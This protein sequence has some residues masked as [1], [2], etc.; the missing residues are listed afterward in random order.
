MF[1]T[2]YKR[3][4]LFV[5]T[6]SCTLSLLDSGL[7]GLLLQPIKEDLHL[8]DTQLGLLTGIVFGLFYAVLG[9]P[10]ARWADRG[11]RTTITGV[12][13]ALWGLAVMTSLFV[14]N[15]MQLLLM[16]IGA[17]VG[18][19]G[20]RPP[21]YSL[22]GDYF[23]EAAERTRAMALYWTSGPLAALL[24]FV[25]GGWLN[26]QY[27]WRV[28][29]FLVGIPG[30]LAAL[31]V[32]LSISEPRLRVPRVVTTEQPSPRMLEVLAT[33]WRRHATRHI[34]IALILVQTMAVGLNPWIAAFMIRSHGM[35]TTEVGLWLGS[36]LG[37]G[38]FAGALLGGYVSA[39]WFG[40]DER[41]QMRMSAL[42]ISAL[43]PC[44]AA[45]LLLP[46]RHQALMALVPWM[47][48][49]GFFVGPTYALLQRLV[50]A[51]MR[52]TSLALL[53]LFGNLI[54][55]GVGPLIVG[56]LSDLLMPAL[57]SDS[58]RYAMLAMC[59][60]ALWAACHFWIVGRTVADDLRTAAASAD[61]Q[62]VVGARPVHALEGSS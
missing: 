55:L 30:L 3:Y 35:G 59:S 43:V 1:S 32:K 50:A 21:T 44:F 36:I 16:R 46:E 45:F 29:F 47:V 12:A 5:L 60:V 49:F 51:Q 41:G 48:S 58:L 22:V 23:P 20:V 2:G 28:T 13:L 11:N 4:V 17:A 62:G 31:V 38:G 57:G 15:F 26:E 25:A 27:G 6:G 33:M 53:M 52:A 24:S 61:E 34:V 42:T 9:L 18:D 14:S 56:I 54:G 10:M 8:S 39:R 7:L 37:L 40:Q 19:A